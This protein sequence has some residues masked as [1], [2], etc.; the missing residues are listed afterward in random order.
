MRR[1]CPASW[2][3]IVSWRARSCAP[4]SRLHLATP[5]FFAAIGRCAPIRRIPMAIRKTSARAFAAGVAIARLRLASGVPW[6]QIRSGHERALT[7]SP[8][9]AWRRAQAGTCHDTAGARC[10]AGNRSTDPDGA[11]RMETQTT[12]ASLRAPCHPGPTTDAPDKKDPGA[13]ASHE[14]KRTAS[15]ATKPAPPAQGA[16]Y[17]ESS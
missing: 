16:E 12:P 8:P 9:P 10:A 11:Y 13:L 1:P 2:P 17:P 3:M 6:P 5:C 14:Q 15:R 4:P 7:G